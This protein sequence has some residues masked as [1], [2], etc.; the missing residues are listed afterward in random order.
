MCSSPA[1]SKAGCTSAF[2]KNICFLLLK[3]LSSNEFCVLHLQANRLGFSEVFHCTYDPR[4]KSAT[5]LLEVAEVTTEKCAKGS[6]FLFVFGVVEQKAFWEL[7][8]E[9]IV[10]CI[11]LQ[12]HS[13]CSE[14]LT[15]AF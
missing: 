5:K 1:T 8:M 14:T 9:Q 15:H 6:N 12:N 11:E 2:S 3:V 13:R 10:K 7:G 4:L